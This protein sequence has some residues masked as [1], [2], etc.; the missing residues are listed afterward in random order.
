[1]NL[2]DVRGETHAL[3]ELLVFGA[4]EGRLLLGVRGVLGVFFVLG[5]RRSSV[6][7][8][9]LAA[10]D[11]HRERVRSDHLGVKVFFL[12]PW[13]EAGHHVAVRVL[14]EDGRSPSSIGPFA[15]SPGK[16]SALSMAFSKSS[17]MRRIGVARST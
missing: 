7:L 11:Q 17:K 2:V 4:E 1:M 3:L 13:R 9:A 15:S 5:V 8:L 6:L 10:H 14:P 12:E 16:A